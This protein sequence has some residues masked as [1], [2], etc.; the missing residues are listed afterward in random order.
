[1]DKGARSNSGRTRG[2]GPTGAHDADSSPAIE[3][4]RLTKVYD[5]PSRTN[6]QAQ[7]VAADNL[8]LSVPRGEV[9]GLVGP[10]G[11]GKTTTLKMICGLLA[12]TAGRIT[13]NGI[14]VARE[15]EAAQGF[16]GYLADFFSLYDE[17]KVWEYLD[18]FAH[19]YKMPPETIPG[20]IDYA[21][22]TLGL[23]TK[24]DAFIAG[25]S[26]GMKQRLGI[27]R[28]ILHD[29]RVLILD[30]PA[31]GLDPKSRTEFKGLIKDLHRQGKTVFITSH[32]LADL[33]EI[34]TWV[35]I[36]EKGRLL[37]VGRI[38]Q[39]IREA[40]PGRRVRFKI[41]TPGFPLAEWMAA[42]PWVTDVMPEATGVSVAFGGGET[43]LAALVRALA[44]T[45][46]GVYAVEEV[47]ETLE[48]VVSRLSAGEVM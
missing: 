18:Y 39:V 7:V 38:D 40:A 36:I 37:R 20:R 30:E 48:R 45:D 33:E 15:P 44:M 29:P 1:L 34:C 14:N 19:A 41:S 3:L 11:A 10:N 5:L 35:A 12:P 6:A 42:R 4:E 43:E 24:R 47:V 8:S 31:V 13:V 46:A 28:A 2:E 22:R 32:L 9:F 25:L 21:I 17:L 16:I 26:R 27:A 23:E